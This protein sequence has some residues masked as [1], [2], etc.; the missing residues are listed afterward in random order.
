MAGFDIRHLQS[1]VMAVEADVMGDAAQ[2]D[3]ERR[4]QDQHDH[5]H[6]I[7][8]DQPADGDVTLR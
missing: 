5:H 1:D 7:L 2:R 8:D 3:G 6:Q 4:Q